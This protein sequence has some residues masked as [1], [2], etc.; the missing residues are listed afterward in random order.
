MGCPTQF[1]LQ[2][3][4]RQGGAQCAH[5]GR[6]GLKGPKR[7]KNGRFHVCTFSVKL[8]GYPRILSTPNRFAPVLRLNAGT[9]LKTRENDQ[10]NVKVPVSVLDA[11]HV[12][13]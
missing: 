5:S 3:R 7:H 12:E 10:N 1:N 13:W 2:D 11:P 9:R 8:M 4:P 6:Q